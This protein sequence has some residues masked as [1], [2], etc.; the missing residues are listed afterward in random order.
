MRSYLAL[1]RAYA[2]TDVD[3]RAEQQRLQILAITQRRVKVGPT[4]GWTALFFALHPAT[5]ERQF[6]VINGYGLG[7]EGPLNHQTDPIKL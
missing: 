3:R 7:M 1:D 2:L 6:G 5:K 4:R